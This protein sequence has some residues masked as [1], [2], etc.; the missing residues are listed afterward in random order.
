MTDDRFRPSVTVAAIVERAGRFLIVQ[1][2]TWDGLKLNNPAGHL[3]PC[4]SLV[5]A[6]VRE[7][8]EETACH[9]TPTAWLGVYHARQQRERDGQVEDFSYVRFAFV[10]TVS[11][12]EPGRALDEGIVQTLWLTPE[13]L[14]EREREHRSP[15]LM[16]C[17]EDHLGGQRL[18]LSAL[19]TD[20]SVTRL[21]RQL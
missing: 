6:C 4:E 7:C 12:P 3:D 10:G 1:E 14:R 11:E 20:A 8:L 15:M 13:E 16:R 2:N 21:G 9:F 5:D 18:P 17:V 19:K